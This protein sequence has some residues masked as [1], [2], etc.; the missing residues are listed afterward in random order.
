MYTAV[1]SAMSAAAEANAKTAVQLSNSNVAH[2]SVS[3][4]DMTV[5]AA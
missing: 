4:K 3:R 5:S 1:T 2:T